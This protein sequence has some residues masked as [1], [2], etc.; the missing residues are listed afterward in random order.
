[1]KVICERKCWIIAE[2]ILHRVGWMSVFVKIDKR[3]N[4]W[5]WGLGGSGHLGTTAW[6]I[7]IG[8]VLA[9]AHQCKPWVA[10]PLIIMRGLR[11]FPHSTLG[12]GDHTGCQL[13]QSQARPLAGCLIFRDL[14]NKN[15]N[16][17]KGNLAL[18]MLMMLMVVGRGANYWL[19]NERNAGTV[20]TLLP[21]TTD[22]H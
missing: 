17:I 2:I 16:N 8:I 6:D 15:N 14:A 22:G 5:G 4:K 3:L 21:G 7:H 11:W 9:H 19:W 20:V 18:Y 10:G 13:E 1:M 12:P